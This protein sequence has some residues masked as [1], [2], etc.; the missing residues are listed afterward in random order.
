MKAHFL[1]YCVALLTGVVVAIVLTPIIRNRFLRHGIV[2]K[3]SERKIHTLAVPR[4]G[5]IALFVGFWCAMLVMMVFFPNFLDDHGTQDRIR[6]TQGLFWASLLVFLVGL[7]DDLKSMKAYWKLLA[8]L[9]AAYILILFGVN[10]EV[11]SN[12]FGSNIELGWLSYPFTML[13]VSG[14]IVSVNFIDGLDGLASGVGIMICMTFFLIGIHADRLY[15]SI[16][17]IALAGSIVGFLRHNFFP[18]TI[19]MGDSGSMFLGLVI[20]GLGLMSSQKSTVS[21]TILTPLIAMGYPV[22]DTLLTIIRR[23]KSKDLFSAERGH[24]H[25]VLLSQGYSHPKT[26]VFL[27]II[28]L[29]F[30]T[31]AFLFTVFNESSTFS[32]GVIIFVAIFT[33]LFV[34]I[35]YIFKNK[36]QNRDNSMENP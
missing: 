7:I 22:I 1:E 25:H 30:A 4:F 28:C 21:F 29:F 16:V 2:D 31:M 35:I 18:A 14:I 10:V 17:S 15:I 27:Y 32:V 24:I 23:S 5:G 3:P 20:A 9:S 19:F 11:I 6:Q 34:K 33:L 8:E 36:T 13:W 12:P 26:V